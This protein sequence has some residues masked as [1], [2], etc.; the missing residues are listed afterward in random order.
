MLLRLEKRLSAMLGECLKLIT[1]HLKWVIDFMIRL[2]QLLTVAR[3]LTLNRVAQLR[4]YFQFYW[5]LLS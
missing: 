2:Y 5:R 3:R 1:L 4:E